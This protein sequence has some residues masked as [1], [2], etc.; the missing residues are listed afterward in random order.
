MLKY[1]LI[2]KQQ[3]VFVDCIDYIIISIKD[4][5]TSSIGQILIK[6]ENAKIRK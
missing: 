1:W 4:L 3:I 2:I 6:F 5:F